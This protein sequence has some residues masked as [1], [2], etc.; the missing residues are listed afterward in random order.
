M[1]TT[2]WCLIH[3]PHM[4]RTSLTVTACLCLCVWLRSYC[5]SFSADLCIFTGLRLAVAQKSSRWTAEK[6]HWFHPSRN[7]FPWFPPPYP[8]QHLIKL[9]S[10]SHANTI[11]HLSKVIKSNF[12]SLVDWELTNCWVGKNGGINKTGEDEF[13]INSE[14]NI[15]AVK[16]GPDIWLC[17]FSLHDYDCK[18]ETV[19]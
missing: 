14:E 2:A 8:A 10:G 5:E 11:C 15:N 7:P 4:K 18:T 6:A 16:W 13:Y 19:V 12:F 1:N 3:S 17:D 9:F